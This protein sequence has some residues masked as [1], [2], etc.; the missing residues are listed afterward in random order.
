M[1][2]PESERIII[3]PEIYQ[4]LK[5]KILDC[6]KT[7]VKTVFSMIENLD[8]EKNLVYIMLLYISYRDWETDRKSVV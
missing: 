3:T 2:S 5:H 1:E 6:D 4:E 8:Y 7:D